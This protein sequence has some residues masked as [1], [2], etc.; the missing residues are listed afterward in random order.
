[1]FPIACANAAGLAS[2]VM[3]STAPD[4][5]KSWPSMRRSNGPNSAALTVL[6]SSPKVSLE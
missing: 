5:R 1:V 3:A 2:P 6:K 4:R